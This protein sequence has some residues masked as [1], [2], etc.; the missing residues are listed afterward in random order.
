M[1]QNSVKTVYNRKFIQWLKDAWHLA[2]PYWK[3]EERYTAYAKLAAVIALNLAYVYITVVANQWYNSFYD[4]LQRYDKQS[5]VPLVVKFCWIAFFNVLLQL[6]SFYIRKHL[7]ISWR[8]WLTDKY[9]KDWLG[10]QSYYK[11]RFIKPIDNPDQ[12]ISEDINSFI[13]LTLDLSLGLI[14][15]LVSLFSFVFILWK[16]SGVLSFNLLGHGWNIH[17]YLVW[18]A[19]LY[20]LAGTYITF[21]IGRPLIKLNFQ[22]QAYEADFRFGLLRVREYSEDIAFYQGEAQESS[23]L[24]RRFHNVVDNFFK[25]VKRTLK[26]NGFGFVYGQTSVLFPLLICVPRY[27]SKV[28]TLGQLMQITSAFGRV[29]DALSYFLNAY[30]SMA[31]WRAVMDRMYGFQEAVHNAGELSGIAKTAD[32]HNYLAVSDLLIN[33]P[34]TAQ[35][36]VSNISFR[37]NSGDRLLIRGRSGSGKTTLLRTLAGLW[38]FASG[39]ISGNPDKSSLFIAQKP[40]I[41]A[42]NLK[43]AICYPLVDNLPSDEAVSKIMRECGIAYLGK[44]LHETAD[45]GKMLSL[46]EQQRIAF[47]RILINR[48]D[49]VYMDESTSALDEEMEQHLYQLLIEQLPQSA[50]ISVGHRST[51]RQWHNQELNFNDLVSV[52]E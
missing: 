7:E 13:G 8:R 33:L 3:S 35:P 29:Q 45:W 47:C 34:K 40:Y 48:P 28:I 43:Q 36:L 44:R 20:A 14:T 11:T 12:R 22:Q 4:A 41:P 16:L 23:G 2:R 15:S 26:I 32:H 31:G 27:L 38:P 17:G 50:L 52:N 25:V 30:T 10:R 6:V 49:I 1:Q 37:L 21:K 5:F 18:L 24:S 42:I 51:L 39:K 9:L 46:G 19:V